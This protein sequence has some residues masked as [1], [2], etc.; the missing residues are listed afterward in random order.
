VRTRG[1]RTDLLEEPADGEITVA[2]DAVGFEVRPFEAVT[3]RVGFDP[4]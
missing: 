3:L 1:E 2:G 4:G